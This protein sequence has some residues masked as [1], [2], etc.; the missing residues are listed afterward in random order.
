MPQQPG[1]LDSLHFPVKACFPSCWRH[2]QA[3]SSG[4]PEKVVGSLLDKNPEALGRHGGV[5]LQVAVDA[6]SL[7]THKT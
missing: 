6:P 3:Y 2:L 7:L 4:I 5:A 1:V